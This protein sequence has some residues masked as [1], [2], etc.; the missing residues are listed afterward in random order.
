MVPPLFNRDRL[1]KP[2]SDI[3]CNNLVSENQPAHSALLCTLLRS[4][5]PPLSLFSTRAGQ[6]RD[7]RRIREHRDNAGALLP[8]SKRRVRSVSAAPVIIPRA[9]NMWPRDLD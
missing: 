3:Q 2:L 9:A 8:K 4:C 5:P 6:S 1:L 7:S